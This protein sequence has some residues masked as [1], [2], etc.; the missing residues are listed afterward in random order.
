MVVTMVQIPIQRKSGIEKAVTMADWDEEKAFY[1][2]F[3]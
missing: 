3:E 2:E 1:W